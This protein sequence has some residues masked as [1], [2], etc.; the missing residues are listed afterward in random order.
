MLTFDRYL[1]KKVLLSTVIGVIFMSSLALSAQLIKEMQDI[2]ALDGNGLKILAQFLALTFP[3]MLAYMLP[4][5]F[6]TAALLTLNALSSHNEIISIRMTGQNHFRI[7]FPIIILGALFSG[8]LY[9][10][11]GS[12]TPE[13]RLKITELLNPTKI[14][15]GE[16]KLS[17]LFLKK[18]LGE[19]FYLHTKDIENGTLRGVHIFETNPETE[20][21]STYI[22][23]RSAD[24]KQNKQGALSVDA[25]KVYI[26]TKASNNIPEPVLAE[27]VYPLKIPLD[28]KKASNRAK[29]Q[30]NSQIMKFLSETEGDKEKKQI[31]KSRLDYFTELCTRISMSISCLSFSLIAF[32]LGLQSKRKQNNRGF[33]WGIVTIGAFLGSLE[34]LAGVGDSF[35]AR[36]AAIFIP[37]L[38]ILV[39][40]AVLYKKIR[41]G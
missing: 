30:T 37:H 16:I 17:P 36:G 28:K 18:S 39:I 25:S 6:L 41:I 3:Y 40:A 4:W 32:P 8:L 19:G 20:E 2:F 1:F 34:F 21:V 29:Y 23:A 7:A 13:S 38:V 33:I 22:Y 5:A 24:L 15:D 35:S 14:K 11:N 10:T 31:K 9:Y 26:Q 12:L 27:R